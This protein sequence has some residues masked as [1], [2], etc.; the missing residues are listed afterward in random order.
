MVTK[1]C[2]AEAI[3]WFAVL[4]CGVVQGL[5]KPQ[6]RQ[7]SEALGDLL[8]PTDALGWPRFGALARILAVQGLPAS[9][10]RRPVA[11][12]SYENPELFCPQE[13]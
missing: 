2:L 13:V 9:T 10:M 7:H 4:L 3:T 11:F 1:D 5:P 8:G 12:Y 6:N